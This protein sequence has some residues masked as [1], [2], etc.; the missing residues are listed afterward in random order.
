MR[1]PQR[2]LLENR[3][4]TAIDE[5]YPK[6]RLDHLLAST[7]LLDTYV[8]KGNS[9]PDALLT[10]LENDLHAPREVILYSLAQ[11]AA[12]DEHARKYK[13]LVDR[14]KRDG[15]EK[16]VA[17]IVKHVVGRPS[18]ARSN[19]PY[20]DSLR[21]ALKKLKVKYDAKKGKRA[22]FVEQL[23]LY[24]RDLRQD[25]RP[26][27]V[28]DLNSAAALSAAT[29]PAPAAVQ[30]TTG[31][32][33]AAAAPCAALASACSAPGAALAAMVA[34]CAG[35]S[36]GSAAS[37]SP[38]GGGVQRG[39]SLDIAARAARLGLEQ[40]VPD[41]TETEGEDEEHVD[42]QDL[43]SLRAAEAQCE[44]L[45]VPLDE[46]GGYGGERSCRGRSNDGGTSASSRAYRHPAG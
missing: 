44:D 41:R 6:R 11:Q 22:V 37:A 28:G 26:A 9:L 5:F 42:S 25:K 32:T 23:W 7:A 43:K 46:C 39:T 21:A 18:D 38:A 1:L 15:T 16:D 40:R 27:Y 45:E 8:D 4:P 13:A 10:A 35:A 3:A 14:Q 19:W 30:T 2:I 17:G 20:I 33:P 36:T 34:A 24:W 12:K 29:A 31:N